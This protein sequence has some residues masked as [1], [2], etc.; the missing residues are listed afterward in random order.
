MAFNLSRSVPGSDAPAIAFPIYPLPPGMALMPVS[1]SAQMI[2]ESGV[3]SLQDRW[4]LAEPRTRDVSREALFD[5][6]CAGLPISDY[7]V[8]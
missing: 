2:L 4:S 1:R 8:H 5:A 6:Y 3:S 7:V